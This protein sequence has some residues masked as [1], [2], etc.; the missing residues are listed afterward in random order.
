MRDEMVHWAFAI[1]VGGLIWAAAASAQTGNPIGMPAGTTMKAPGVPA[2]YQANT[3]D[4][5]F[6][7]QL[8]IGG[9]AEVNLGKL[10]E[11]RGHDQAVKHFAK[12]MVSDHE[13]ANNRLMAVVKGDGFALPRE[14]D[15]D[16]R[17]VG[18]R[19]GKLNGADFDVAY[20]AAQ[21]EDHQKTVQLLEYEIGSGEDQNL[22]NFAAETLPVV[23]KHLQMARAIVEKTTPMAPA[24]SAAPPGTPGVT[25][26]IGPQTPAAQPNQMPP[27]SPNRAR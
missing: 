20:M 22:K 10:A 26:A 7:N 6:A 9:L 17:A 14:L 12:H 25:P 24:A 3:A 18:E 1:S 4:R 23:W 16:H 19:L 13:A 2:P 11:Q 21:L 8:A 15:A 27:A 5:V